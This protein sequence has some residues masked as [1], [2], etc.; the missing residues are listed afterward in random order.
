MSS[1]RYSAMDETVASTLHL[2][3]DAPSVGRHVARHAVRAG[4]HPP[5][6]LEQDLA[7][8]GGLRRRDDSAPSACCPAC[9]PRAAAVRLLMAEATMWCCSAARAMLRV[10]QT[11]DEKTQGL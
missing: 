11:A 10:S 9:S 1:G 8:A 4:Q 6:M 3:L 2:P 5:R 7:G